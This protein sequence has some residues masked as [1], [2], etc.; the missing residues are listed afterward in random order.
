MVRIQYLGFKGTLDIDTNE[1]EFLNKKFK[2][3]FDGIDYLN[4]V[5]VEENI[6]KDFFLNNFS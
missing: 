5:L 4:K 1:V 3:I 2:N 6:L